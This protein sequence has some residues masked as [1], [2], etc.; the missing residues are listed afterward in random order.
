MVFL[1][2]SMT[3]SGWSACGKRKEVRGGSSP[4]EAIP[5]LAVGLEGLKAHPLSREFSMSLRP[6][7][8]GINSVEQLGGN[9]GASSAERAVFMCFYGF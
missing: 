2:K 9:F 8:L 5:A 7:D 6:T 1:C 4:S 3:L